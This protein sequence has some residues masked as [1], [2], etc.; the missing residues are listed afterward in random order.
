ME[1]RSN[2]DDEQGRDLPFSRKLNIPDFCDMD[3]FEQIIKDWAESTGLATVA[4]G[5]DGEYISSCYHFTEFCF[6]LTRKS[7]E[8]L[9]RCIECDRKGRGIYLC[10]AGL[11]DF[12]TP[13]TLEDGTVLGSILGGQVLSERPDELH[14][15]A[16]AREL[17]I[18]EDAYIAALHRVNIR[19]QEEIR[20]SADLLANVINLFVR[21]SYTARLNAASLTERAQIISSLSKIYFCDYYIDLHFDLLLELDATD[22]MHAFLGKRRKASEILK[23]YCCI[24]SVPEHLS[25]LLEFTDLSTLPGRLSGRQ[26][27]SHEFISSF[28][29]WC[30]AVFIEVTCN[31][32][33]DT[34]H[35]I[36]AL[37]HIQEDKEKELNARKILEETAEKANQANRAK[38]DFLAQMS[39]E[40]RTPL[41]GIIGLSYLAADETR[42]AA[43]IQHY[44]RQINRSGEYLL[45]IINNILDMSN[46]ENKK[47]KL[48]PAALAFTDICETLRDVI[49]VQC[50]KKRQS[51]VIDCPPE[52]LPP[53]IKADRTHFIQIFVNLLMNSVMYTPEGGHIRFHAEQ[54][55]HSGTSSHVRFIIQDDGAGMTPELLAAV[56][57]PF[58]RG[59]D[60]KEPGAGL[61]LAI[62]KSLVELMGGTIR[63]ESSVGCG[64][65]AAVDMNLETM[66]G[67]PEQLQLSTACK[68][69]TG[70]RFLLCEDNDINAEIVMLL[71]E[72]V[73]ASADRAENG[74][75]GVE[76]FRLSRQGT[77]SAVLMDIR[78]PQMDGLTAAAV[79]RAMQRPD[80]KT[81]PII[82]LT[83]N[84][85]EEDRRSSEKA[86]MNAHLAKP[87]DP[88]AL[89]STLM[90]Y[91]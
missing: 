47:L 32:A 9:R 73:G 1:M 53:Y 65:T 71:L 60:E 52:D 19:T 7:P 8:G 17:G 4:L 36:F 87:V 58:E 41:S 24:Y 77:Y 46:I 14:F 70:K 54:I 23:D 26:S 84:A 72:N 67:S 90:Q 12:A 78:M 61:G 13:I 57:E 66:A 48:H 16:T 6:S 79:I 11:V 28:S 91:S 33:S 74:E 2:L 34:S 50:E 38:S 44:I 62:V 37:Q 29:G 10:H 82:A 25:D 89:Y 63:I 76:K 68:A 35:V 81:I 20:A 39:H 85:F 31:E 69:L 83:A 42:T 55:S 56:F 30:R 45:G 59:P 80:A 88:G 18:D 21:S 15:R 3:R 40:L 86:G 22:E 51:F 43:E 5:R 49:G 27:I 75:I 64:T